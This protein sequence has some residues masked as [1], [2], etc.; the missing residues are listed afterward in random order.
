MDDVL[1]CCYIKEYLVKLTIVER[2]LKVFERK[3]NLFNS[4]KKKK[5]NGFLMIFYGIEELLKIL[6]VVDFYSKKTRQ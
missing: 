5:R 1:K 3:E 2:S 4:T 6:Y